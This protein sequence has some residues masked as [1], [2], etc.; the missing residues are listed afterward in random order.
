MTVSD[1]AAPDLA[2]E[3]LIVGAGPAGLAV[4]R[5]YRKAGGVGTVLLVGAEEHPPY[6]RP[7]LT[8]DYLR[9]ESDA[10]ALPLAEPEWYEDNSVQLRLATP[11]TAVDA[12][13]RHVTLSDGT[14]VRYERLALATGSSPSPLPVPGG[15][16]PGVIYVRDRNS[17][18]ALRGIAQLGRNIVVIGSGF[19]GCEVAASLSHRGAEVV[20]VT[21]EDL[22]HAA[23]LGA[24]AGK[25]IRDWLI[26]AGVVLVLGDGVAAISHTDDDGWRVDLVSGRIL[27]AEAVVSGS[28]ARPNLALASSAGVRV[29]NGGVVTDHGLRTCD[30][31]I[32]AVGDIAYAHNPAAGRPLR[33]E[34]W[35]EAES[36]GEIA[37]ANIAGQD[38]RWD[39]APGFWSGIGQRGLKYSAWGDGH[40]AAR[41]VE[42]PDGAWAVW[43]AQDSTTVGVLAFEWDEAYERGQDLI[44]RGADISE[45][46]ALTGVSA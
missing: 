37:G 15:D 28:G 32:W 43:Y 27:S 18:E 39:G 44:E 33:V 41:L 12:T 31:H 46:L 35:G 9:G 16:L 5:G 22:P 29:E 2:V 45:A 7:P 1:G 13:R 23:R 10:D 26:D 6:A 14:V 8:K 40:D 19:I 11:A 24:E 36:M 20:L 25:R 3:L 17:A 34:H 42:G 30:P 38:R 21:D 4:A